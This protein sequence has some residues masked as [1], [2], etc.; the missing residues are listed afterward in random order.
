V[1]TRS[2]VL[3]RGIVAAGGPHVLFTVPAGQTWIIKDVESQ[4]LL[5]G[6]TFFTYEFL[7]PTG[8]V[9]GFINNSVNANGFASNGFL[10]VVANAGDKVQLRGAVNPLSVWMSGAKL[11]GVA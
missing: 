11:L 2:T 7:D 5:V 1:P 6:N 3:F 4:D 9:V 10:W 8:V